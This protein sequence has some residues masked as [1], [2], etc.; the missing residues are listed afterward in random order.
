MLFEIEVF[1]DFRGERKQ[2]AGTDLVAT[3]PEYF[4]CP[5]HAADIIVFF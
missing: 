2:A 5:A 3:T 4:P 1:L